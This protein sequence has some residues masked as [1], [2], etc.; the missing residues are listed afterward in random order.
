MKIRKGFVSNSSSSSFLLV[1]PEAVS[2][3]L[4][5]GYQYAPIKKLTKSQKT[6]IC[7]RLGISIPKRQSVYLT[8]FLSDTY[9]HHPMIHAYADGGHGGPYDEERY[10]EI[11]TDIWIR[12]EDNVK[13]RSGFVSNSSSSSFVVAVNSTK[14]DDVTCRVELTADLTQFG[15]V[16]KNKKM[17]KQIAEDECWDMDL[18]SGMYHDCLMA[19]ENKQII[20]VGDFSN[21]TEDYAELAL[22]MNGIHAKTNPH[23]TIISNYEGF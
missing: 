4:S 15:K 12:K 13:V 11:D 18:D 7:D 23:I 17:L 20:I 1:G 14:K 2:H 21:D 16:I 6:S 22:C 3:I 9:F 8:E 19:L 10:D 5:E